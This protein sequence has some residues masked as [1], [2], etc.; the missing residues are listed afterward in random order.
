MLYKT[1]TIY[2][3]RRAVAS[4]TRPGG[5]PREADNNAY[6]TRY[7]GYEIADP[8]YLGRLRSVPGTDERG[9]NGAAA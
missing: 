6:N 7:G 9:A 5:L 4:A 3:R 8:Q 2:R 1:E